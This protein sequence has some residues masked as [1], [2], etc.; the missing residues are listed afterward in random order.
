MT[1]R[2]QNELLTRT[3]PATPMGDL[4][5]RYWIPVLMAQELPVPD[6]SPIRVKLLS[7][8]LIA[9]RD[10]NGKLGLIDEFCAH[11]RVSL[12]FGRNEEGGIRCPYHGWKYDTSGQ[13]LDIPSEPD[14]S[15]FC[16]KVK[17][18]SYPCVELGG[19]IW[20]Y[21]GPSDKQPPLPEFEW[22]LVPDSHRYVS[23]RIQENNY[24][25]AMEGGIDSSHV[26]WLHSGE[27]ANDPLHVGTEGAKHIVN[28]KPVFE[29]HKSEGGLVIAAKR[30]TED[31]RAYWRV[32][33]W[34]LPWYTMIPPYG[35]NALR[36]HAWVP[37]DDEHCITWNWA[38]HPTRP[39][40][41]DEMNAMANENGAF[42][43]LIPGT[44]RP[45]ANKDN[46]YLMD[47]AGQKSGRYYSGIKG[48][49][50]QDASLQ[51]SMGPIVDRS[52]ERLVSTDIAIVQ[53][54]RRL[55]EAA[56]DVQKGAPAPGL[57][58]LLHH[59]RS[60][61]FVGASNLAFAELQTA[62]AATAG[63]QPTSV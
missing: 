60:A 23:K 55:M 15:K 16:N 14:G 36:G 34:I 24:L 50:M 62:L 63:T 48:I 33:Q 9:F 59:V 5:R 31:D 12:W 11:R 58:P 49:A 30:P 18:N 41:E 27:L 53:A 28:K 37:I 4:F 3:G 52:M 7:E 1:T 2:E 45:V 56:T 57:D 19:V 38:H 32:T 43:A 21:M 29:L 51:E 22:A 44:F 54:R 46:D 26:S 47:R 20:T 8:H 10:S 25:Q 39:L 13:C 35:D 6:C 61:S 42:A 40:T 17:L